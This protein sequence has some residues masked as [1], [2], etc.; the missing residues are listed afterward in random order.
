M[1]RTQLFWGQYLGIETLLT[2]IGFLTSEL[3]IFLFSSACKNL[4]NLCIRLTLEEEKPTCPDDIKIK[5]WHSR[6]TINSLL[7]TFDMETAERYDPLPP[8]SLKSIVVLVHNKSRTIE[9]P[10]ERFIQKI[11]D[12]SSSYIQCLWSAVPFFILRDMGFNIKNMIAWKE[13][14][15]FSDIVLRQKRPSF[16]E[17]LASN[18]Y[19]Q[20]G[21]FNVPQLKQIECGFWKDV[22]IISN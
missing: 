7:E 12:K 3:L 21:D 6:K 19:M 16:L 9:G 11:V 2:T 8:R 20:R 22:R 17:S 4:E 18:K 10:M 1:D 14:K 5:D 13:T 15:N